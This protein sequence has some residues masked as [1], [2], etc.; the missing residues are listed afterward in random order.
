MQEQVRT[1]SLSIR[2][3]KN[4]EGTKRWAREAHKNSQDSQCNNVEGRKKKLFWHFF[5]IKNY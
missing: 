2:S 5:G 1:I 3:N 4:K